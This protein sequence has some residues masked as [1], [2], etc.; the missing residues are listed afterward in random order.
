MGNSDANSNFK[1]SYDIPIQKGDLVIRRDNGTIYMLNWQVQHLPNNQTTQAINCNA[2]LAFERHVDEQV[3]SRGFLT[4]E[5]HD[6]VIAPLIPCVYSEYAGRPDYAANYNT[7][8]IAADHL[9]NVQVQWNERTRN[10][11][12]GDEFNLLHSR[13]RLVNLVGTELDLNQKRGILNLMARKV[14]GEEKP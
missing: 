13:Y 1:T 9:L 7:P 4:R 6:E 3:D 2:M 10:L 8:G 14:A 5:A 12:T 11:R